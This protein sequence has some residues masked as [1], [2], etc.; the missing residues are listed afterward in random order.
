MSRYLL[1][2]NV[3]SELIRPKPSP[4]VER[5][6]AATS[7]SSNYFSVISL[8]EVVRGIA[9]HSDPIQSAKLQLWLDLKLRRW[10]A[11]RLL[12]LM[13]QTAELAGRIIGEQQKQGR[14]ISFT[15]AAIAATALEYDLT[16]VTRNIRDFKDL[17]LHRINP[18][19]EPA[20]L[21]E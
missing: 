19:E 5:W 1:D 11:G 6:V 16:L 15:D 4:Q 8:A 2:T 21:S 10:F 14:Q 9:Q 3:P 18:W 12:P 7:R 13:P 17:G 20:S